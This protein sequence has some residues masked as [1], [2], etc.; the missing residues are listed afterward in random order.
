MSVCAYWYLK[1]LKHFELCHPVT[2][3]HPNPMI[4]HHT[5]KLFEVN[6]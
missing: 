6:C 2:E 4:D 5:L 3:M 1:V